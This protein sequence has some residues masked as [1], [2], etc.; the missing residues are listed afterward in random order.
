LNGRAKLISGFALAIGLA[1]LPGGC[2][3]DYLQNTDRVSYKAGNAV[4]ANLA[5]ET[6]NPWRANMYETRGLGKNGSVIPPPA[7]ASSSTTTTSTSTQNVSP[8]G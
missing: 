7:V 2:T 8:G 4:R 6:T 1:T 3:Y 5:M